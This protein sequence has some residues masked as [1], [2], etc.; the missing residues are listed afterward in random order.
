MQASSSAPNVWP[1]YV[2]ATAALA[3][4]LLLLIGFLGA[5]L[6]VLGRRTAQVL[7]AAGEIAAQSDATSATSATPPDANSP[8][9]GVSQAIPRDKSTETAP[10]TVGSPVSGEA[11][12]SAPEQA[13][14]AAPPSAVAPPPWRIV[15]A[16]DNNAYRLDD[17]TQ[18]SMKAAIAQVAHRSLRVE[19]TVKDQPASTAR[20][21]FVRVM[22]VR[23]A[24]LDAGIPSS[25][26]LPAVRSG[27]EAPPPGSASLPGSAGP[28]GRTVV[29]SLSPAS[30]EQDTSDAR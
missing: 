9:A 22:A 7:H 14:G 17:S 13:R 29:I 6:F 16:F 20:A 30:L 24:L 23:N 12:A 21:A 10:A 1:G 27:D 11:V 8:A 4:T 18:A 5:N 28:D 25:R 19:A 2:G 26:I 15:V 3:I